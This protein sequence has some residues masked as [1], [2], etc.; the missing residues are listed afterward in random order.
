MNR[1]FDLMKYKKWGVFNIFYR[2]KEWVRGKF[3]D[4]WS[5]F[6]M[7]HNKKWRAYYK[8]FEGKP[9]NEAWGLKPDGSI[10]V[11]KL[12][13]IGK[14]KNIIKNTRTGTVVIYPG[15]RNVEEMQRI[16]GIDYEFCEPYFKE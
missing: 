14:P 15:E 10:K 5:R 8:K 12:N 9:D 7:R 6:H 4:L 11:I 13:E 3:F 2:L 1:Y 16:H